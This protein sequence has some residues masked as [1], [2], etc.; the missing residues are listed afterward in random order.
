MSKAV[1]FSINRPHTDNIKTE[2]K[3]SEL[4]TR[5]PQSWCYVAE[6]QREGAEE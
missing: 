6:L 4:R 2:A 5:P 1:M 3:K